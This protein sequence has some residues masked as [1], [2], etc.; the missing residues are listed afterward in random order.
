MPERFISEKRKVQVRI[1]LGP[2][3]LIKTSEIQALVTKSNA[4]YRDLILSGFCKAALETVMIYKDIR[5]FLSVPF[6]K[7][8]RT[9]V[10]HSEGFFL[11]FFFSI[12]GLKNGR[13][14]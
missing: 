8:C 4:R 6:T 11:S 14:P 1:I 9:V 3:L 13:T 12:K 5:F 7:I 2:H 10:L